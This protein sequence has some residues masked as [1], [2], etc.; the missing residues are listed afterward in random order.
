VYLS[1]TMS[2]S[3][4]MAQSTDDGGEG[5][6]SLHDRYTVVHTIRVDE[7]DND[8][9][10]DAESQSQKQYNDAESHKQYS[11]SLHN[12]ST[13]TESSRDSRTCDSFG[14]DDRSDALEREDS[15]GD[16]DEY[17]DLESLG[18]NPMVD[19]WVDSACSCLDHPI[20]LIQSLGFGKETSLLRQSKGRTRS[21]ITSQ[22]NAISSVANMKLSAA[23]RRNLRLQRKGIHGNGET[24]DIESTMGRLTL[25]D[26]K[27]KE[28]KIMRIQPKERFKCRN[29][30]PDSSGED[31]YSPTPKEV[32]KEPA[33]TYAEKNDDTNTIIS[34]DPIAL[35]LVRPDETREE[36][37]ATDDKT[38]EEL[39]EAGDSIADSFKFAEERTMEDSSKQ[40]E[41]D[42]PQLSNTFNNAKIDPPIESKIASTVEDQTTDSLSSNDLKRLESYDSKTPS[43]NL[44][45]MGVKELKN[46]TEDVQSLSN[47]GDHS[48]V[49]KKRI[50]ESETRH[51]KSVSQGNEIGITDLTHVDTDSPSANDERSQPFSDGNGQK[52]DDASALSNNIEIIDV[53]SMD[54]QD[55]WTPGSRND[56][57][58]SISKKLRNKNHSSPYSVQG[59]TSNH[60]RDA[61]LSSN[62]DQVSDN[63]DDLWFEE[64]EKLNKKSTFNS[65]ASSRPKFLRNAETAEDL[66]NEESFKLQTTSDDIFDDPKA[67]EAFLG[68]RRGKLQDAGMDSSS[69][70]P[71]SQARRRKLQNILRCDGDRG[72]SD[73][74]GS[75]R[76]LRSRS[77]GVRNPPSPENGDLIK[78][79]RS[80]SREGRLASKPIPPQ[81]D[82]EH[83]NVSSAPPS[84]VKE[85][86][87]SKNTPSQKS[88]P[89]RVKDLVVVRS[90]EEGQRIR[91]SKRESIKYGAGSHQNDPINVNKYV[92]EAPI[93]GPFDEGS[94]PNRHR[95][96]SDLQIKSSR[97]RS[98]SR[99]PT[100]T[101]IAK[102]IQS[103]N[104]IHTN[105]ERDD[106]E[107]LE[108]IRPSDARP[109]DSN[110]MSD[111]EN[112]ISATKELRK[113]EK[114]IE[115]QLRQVKRETKS[116]DAWDSQIVP[117]KE[118]RRMEKK[119]AMKLKAVKSDDPD[120]QTVSSMEIRRLEKQ[121][122][123]KLSGDT[124]NRASKLKRIKRKVSKS[125][126]S[127]VYIASSSALPKE[128]RQMYQI[129]SST[130]QLEHDVVRIDAASPEFLLTSTSFPGK[131]LSPKNQGNREE[132]PNSENLIGRRRYLRRGTDNNLSPRSASRRVPVND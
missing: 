49:N 54:D 13:T 105:D 27:N 114:K 51:G 98:K 83:L 1:T 120:S 122:A 29:I 85:R 18:S 129:S 59:S 58:H 4:I 66:W 113:L 14:T 124:E 77:L 74:N 43:E 87:T 28:I 72:D 78:Q 23:E 5:V 103:G 42:Q 47:R 33:A 32:G 8:N 125:S 68:H 56:H 36:E 9:D 52:D 38:N 63:V 57:K 90:I 128:Q 35:N 79:S 67:R 76:L 12:L 20:S 97:Q 10:N 46:N 84:R 21:T 111:Y 130:T 7:N 71:R 132:R 88:V 73:G 53:L 26:A 102:T 3:L 80:K 34:R 109:V 11:V 69:K 44:S 110:N 65:E 55:S 92:E 93:S 94:S 108:T 30:E 16:D 75:N 39:E 86:L 25:D 37:G 82:I 123:Q 96:I 48:T 19:G 24:S 60:K 6:D 106:H 62:G 104:N 22:T 118:I 119:L 17:E 115:K 131:T 112:A 89:S 126:S 50:I 61:T 31:E 40:D 127:S 107:S 100:S 81:K 15:F 121:L 91:S 45:Q 95:R 99:D 101:R 70:S 2:S 64:E 41:D 117:S 116:Q